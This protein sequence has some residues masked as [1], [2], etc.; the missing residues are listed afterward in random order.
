MSSNGNDSKSAIHTSTP[1]E[2]NPSEALS[3]CILSQYRLC[4]AGL[5]L[6]T[7][8]GLKYSKRALIPM[9]VG[10]VVGTVSDYMYGYMI[11]C[12]KEVEVYRQ[13]QTKQK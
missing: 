8:Y 1:E 5:G 3:N 7:A 12:S 2:V 4:A 6:G 13:S 9:A 10:G 11:A